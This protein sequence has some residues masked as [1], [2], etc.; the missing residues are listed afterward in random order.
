MAGDV[1]PA[2]NPATTEEDDRPLQHPAQRALESVPE[3][4]APGPL[5]SLGSSVRSV[6][7]AALPQS[8]QQSGPSQHLS[9]PFD[10]ALGEGGGGLGEM[11]AAAPAS[12]EAAGGLADLA[13]AAL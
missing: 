9:P 10:G 12:G 13:V 8:G 11:N 4:D 2:V 6:L 1:I 3:N 7:G 5:G